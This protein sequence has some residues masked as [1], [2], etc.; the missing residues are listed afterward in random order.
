VNRWVGRLSDWQ[1]VA[2]T[3]G[4]CSLTAVV[5]GVLTVLVVGQLDLA[6]LILYW[7]MFTPMLCAA[8]VHGRR[9]RK[10]HVRR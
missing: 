10:R 5:E 6:R 3:A 4:L 2:V 1:Y 8:C 9:W 7:C